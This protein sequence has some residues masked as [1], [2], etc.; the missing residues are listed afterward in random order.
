MIEDSYESFKNLNFYYFINNK[1]FLNLNS[2]FFPPYAYSHIANVF[3]SDF[4]DFSFH[5]DEN[6]FT[7]SNNTNNFI[8][9][10]LNHNFFFLNNDI[11]LNKFL[12]FNNSINLRNTIKSSIVTYNATQKIFK[13]RFDENRSNTKLSDFS[14]FYIKQPFISSTRPHYENLLGK[15][16]ENFYKV[17]FYKNKFNIFFNNF[18]D[19]STSLNYYFFDFPFLLAFKSD[20]SRYFWFDWFSKWG[21][22]EVQPSSA[23]RYALY[24]MPYFSKNFEFNTN[25]N[26]TFTDNE[27][28]LLRIA[29][30]RKNYLPNWTYTPYLLNKTNNWNKNNQ[31]FN[32][33]NDSDKSLTNTIIFLNHMEWYLNK[34]TFLN[35]SNSLFTPSFSEINSYSKVSWQPKNSIQSYYYNISNLIDILTKREYLYREFLINNNKIINL[36]Y[37]LTSNPSN[38]LINEIKATFLFIDPIMYNNE[39][40]RNIYYNSLSYFNFITLNY[41]STNLSNSINLNFLNNF[42][43]FYFFNNSNQNY[44]SNNFE[45]YR[46]Q[47]K[48]LKKGISSMLRLHVTGAVAMPTEIRLQ[49]LASSKDVIHSWAIPSA[50]IKIDC[51]PGYSSHKVM[52]FLL[53][54]IFWGQC[55]EICG[56]Y[57]HWM[58]IVVYFMKR[59]LFFLWCTH[60]VF[61]SG[62]NNFFNINEKQFTNYARVASFDKNN[63]LTELNN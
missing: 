59:D 48:P 7:K 12:R 17:N 8:N 35:F 1:I 26:E 6:N 46:N 47:Y 9:S 28:Y 15:T 23:S 14:N 41:F 4:E 60:F 39:Y 27:T 62:S 37:Y 57:H 21:F 30:A 36:P 31:L 32:L 5:Y 20:S 13:T 22:Y 58:P 63:W 49:I 34:I 11:D 52:I 40:S 16:K 24:G 45:L 61:L 3:R 54:G 2:I 51:V 43:F 56:R 18:Y 42:I 44:N 29:K 10:N 33:I 53:S 38:P 50:G 55:M 19:L 25:N